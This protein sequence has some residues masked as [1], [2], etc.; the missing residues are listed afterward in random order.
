MVA[1]AHA[2]PKRH[3]NRSIRFA[4]L[5]DVPYT[6]THTNHAVLVEV[7]R[8]DALYAGDAA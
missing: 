1:L 7:G 6:Q 4:W 8:I 5:P 2:A 3:L